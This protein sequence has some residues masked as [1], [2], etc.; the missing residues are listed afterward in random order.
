MG[1]VKLD[2][3]FATHPKV[4]GLSLEAFRFHIQAMCYAAHQRTDGRIPDSFVE[5][6][7]MSERATELLEAGVWERNGVGWVIHD[8]TEYNPS[9]ASRNAKT[10]AASDAARMRWEYDKAEKD[11]LRGIGEGELALGSQKLGVREAFDLFYDSVYPRKGSRPVA[12][13]AFTKAVAKASLETILSGARTYAEDPNREQSFT[14]LPATWLN[15]ECWDDPPL[16]PRGN[17]RVRSD[18]MG[19]G[20]AKAKARRDGSR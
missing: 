17:G 3:G 4:L 9:A 12:F 13:R 2:D 7:H 14:K 15:Q 19:A 16:P 18:A 6:A 1:W 11:A 20:L 5:A 10:H 8:F